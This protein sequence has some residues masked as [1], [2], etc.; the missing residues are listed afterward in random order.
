MNKKALIITYYWPPS[1][2]GGVQ[3]WLKF[4]KYLPQFGWQP[5]VVSP[6]NP[7]YP[8]VDQSLLKDIPAGIEEIKI[9]IWEPYKLFKVLSG[10][11]KQEKVNT[12]ILQNEG[13]KSAVLRL[14]LWLRGNLLIPDPRVFWVRP[15]FQ[16][17]KK[18][19]EILKPDVIITTGPPHSVHL[20]GLKLHRKFGVKWIADFRD[21]WST[22]DYLDW[23][24]PSALAKNR[25]RSLEKRVL[26]EAS[27][28]LTV[29]ENW[30]DELRQL[31]A[32][33]VRVITNGFDEADFQ[34]KEPVSSSG[35]FVL[36]HAGIITSFRN[37]SGLWKAL[38]QLCQNDD[39]IASRFRLRLIGNVD[40]QV[41][42]EI[43]ALSV[44]SQRTEF[45]GYLSHDKVI[46]EYRKASMLLLLM[47]QSHNAAGHIPGKFF[48]YLAAGK[49][50]LGLGDRNGDVA[51]ILEET[52]AGRVFASGEM[53]K[54][55]SFIEMS[56][57]DPKSIRSDNAARFTRRQLSSDLAKLLDSL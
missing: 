33:S 12:G 5:I 13:K 51:R 56:E 44:L 26:T 54:V 36:L 15:A 2:G 55:R 40:E 18:R 47:N 39:V 1:G 53:G 48:E 20:I 17:L 23:F 46:G 38:D 14:A 45:V 9:P 34:Q 21:P 31:G 29:S 24:K 35:D 22:I 7:D 3:R 41:K 50:V 57:A 25:Q 30:A 32:H 49:P 8:T 37:P 19:I 52:K 16:E 42:K 10:K 43:S 28:V 6:E 11:K 4:A 27:S